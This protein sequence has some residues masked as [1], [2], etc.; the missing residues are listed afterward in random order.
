MVFNSLEFYKVG[1][2][3]GGDWIERR[4]PIKIKTLQYSIAS[5]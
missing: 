2:G 3:T 1:A 4:F 5:F